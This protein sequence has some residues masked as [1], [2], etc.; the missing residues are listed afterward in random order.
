MRRRDSSRQSRNS[1][2]VRC[3]ARS[4]NQR[5][6][7]MATV[8]IPWCKCYR[9]RRPR[10]PRFI[11]GGPGQ[12]NFERR[13]KIAQQAAPRPLVNLIE[14][15]LPSLLQFLRPPHGHS[16]V[17]ERRS[18]PVRSRAM[19]SRSYGVLATLPLFGVAFAPRNG[20]AQRKNEGGT[21]VFAMMTK[22]AKNFR[23]GWRVES[24]R[25]GDLAG[26]RTPGFGSFKRRHRPL[27]PRSI[28]RRQ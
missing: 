28:L 24:V 11:N 9:G 16:V 8:S 4:R 10:R 25:H 15:H 1:A 5:T 23:V 12:F 6:L 17:S 13:H 21:V 18:K 2:C 20:Y 19:Q 22:G 27:R 3:S 7:I 14:R 26:R